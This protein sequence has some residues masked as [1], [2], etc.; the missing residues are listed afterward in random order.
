MIKD[1]QVIAVSS[2]TPMRDV[3][4]V[5]DKSAMQIALVVDDS[6]HLLGT[7]TDGDIRRALLRG[8]NLDTP[9]RDFMNANPVTG[10]IDEDPE[11]WQRA[12][13]RHTLQHLPLLDA[14]GCVQALARKEAPQDPQRENPVVLMAGG[15]GTRL[16]PLTDRQPKPL[17]KIGDKPILE[18]IIENFAAQG[19]HRFFLCINY[20]GEKIKQFCGDGRKWGVEIA[21]IEEHKRLGTAGALGLLPVQLD[22]PFF[23]MNGDL[24]TKVDFVRLLGFHQKQQNVATLCVREYR[25]QIPYG[26]VKLNQHQVVN[27][28]EKPVQYYFVN[29]GVYLLEPEVLKHIPQNQYFDMTQLFE[30]LIQNNIKVGS[31]PLREYWMDV[32][33]MEDFEQ[34]HLDYAEQFG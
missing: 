5:I 24:L 22:K 14:N 11:S 21:Y 1:W 32:G 10:L 20:Q 25:Y 15:M 3:L 16:R 8:D 23:V 31:F 4:S 2:A 34:A 9:A 28:K 12:M 33:R 17:L 7:T 30:Y 19:F 26:V 27:L 29:A 13:Q 18:T 6:H